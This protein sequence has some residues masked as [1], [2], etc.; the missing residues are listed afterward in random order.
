MRSLS[1]TS[2]YDV[3]MEYMGS[4]IGCNLLKKVSLERKSDLD[5]YLDEETHL[6]DKRESV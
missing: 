1:F 2:T 6:R 4:W 3:A 5:L